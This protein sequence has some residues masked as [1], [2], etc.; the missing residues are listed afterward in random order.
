MDRRILNKSNTMYRYY[1][2]IVNEEI[3]KRDNERKQNQTPYT[4]LRTQSQ[5][6]PEDKR[7]EKIRA[8]TRTPKSY[9]K[10]SREI[11]ELK[12]RQKS[13]RQ[14]ILK[15]CL[16]IILRKL[17]VIEIGKDLEIVTMGIKTKC[18]DSQRGSGAYQQRNNQELT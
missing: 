11:T 5:R 18:G 15:Q 13:R 17:I 9:Q 10:K 2:L 3:N 6:N 8:I 7:R 14:K 12:T 1:K 16:R 4:P